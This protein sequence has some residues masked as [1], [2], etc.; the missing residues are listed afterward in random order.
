[1][2]QFRVLLIITAVFIGLYT[3]SCENK[4]IEFPNF[5]YS[6]VYFAY[7][8]PVRT[9]V[10]GEDIVDNSL[11]N[12]H[13]CMI[14]ATIG[15]VYSNGKNIEISYQVNNS[16]CNNLFYENGSA[17]EAMPQNYYSLATNS[18]SLEKSMQGGV[19]VQLLDAFFADPKALS[20][21][22]VIP[23]EMTSVVNADSILSGEAK[24]DNP[25]KCNLSDWDVLPK[26]Y[27]LYCVKFINPYHANYLRRGEDII[28]ENGETLRVERSEEWVENDEVVSLSTTSLNS[29]D[30]PV[31]VVNESGNNETCVLTLTFDDNN[32][33]TVSSSSVGFSVTGTGSYV[34]DGEKKSWGDQDRS[35]IYLDYTIEMIGKKYETTDILVYR[36]RGVHLETFSP[37]YN[38]E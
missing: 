14:Y 37:A 28:T 33:C 18:I 11:D 22:Y 23:L 38:A 30:F 25:V 15:G 34:V 32:A 36:D 4:D 13:K 35:A 17:V 27:V 31:T 19:E 12:E 7:Q 21:T 5:D 8:Y 9:I 20:N 24:V 26:D 2:K 16:L 3:T 29:V 6:T 1:M 10:L